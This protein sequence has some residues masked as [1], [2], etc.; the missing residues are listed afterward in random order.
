M[1]NKMTANTKK[2]YKTFV[3]YLTEKTQMKPLKADCKI[4]A[5]ATNNLIFRFNKEFYKYTPLH[6]NFN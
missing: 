1:T 2:L 3:G 4:S 5:V 6:Y